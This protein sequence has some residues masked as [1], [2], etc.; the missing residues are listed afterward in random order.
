MS[1]ADKP[2]KAT[3]LQKDA[4]EF[5]TYKIARGLKRTMKQQT[6]LYSY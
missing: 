2:L 6:T 4:E 5:I 1:R 3:N